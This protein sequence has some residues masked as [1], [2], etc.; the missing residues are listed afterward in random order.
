MKTFLGQSRPMITVMLKSKNTGTLIEEIKRTSAQG[1]EAY[2]LQ[3]EGLQ[4]QYLN[5]QDLT[6]IFQAMEDKP[7]YVTNYARGNINGQNQS[8]EMLAEEL[9]LALDCG[10]VLCDVRADM[11]DRC[12][13]E[14]TLQEAAVKK[15]KELIREIHRKGK[16]A[17]MSSHIFQFTPKEQVYAI[18][19]AMQER[20]ADIAKVVA[21]A[22][23]EKELTEAFETLLLLKKEIVIPTLFLCNGFCSYKHRMLGPLLG[24]CMYLTVENRQEK[25]DMQKLM[26]E[27]RQKRAE[28]Q[29]GEVPA[30]VHITPDIAQARAMIDAAGYSE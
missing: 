7:C 21:I 5:R 3:L 28:Q 27:V 20:G 8:D 4:K 25:V 1:A 6:D 30:V 16:E 29:P 26:E 22:D 11:F 2:G 10:A 23:D 14:F 24:S 15:Q 17:L 13:G 19:H 9:L 18:A 12:M